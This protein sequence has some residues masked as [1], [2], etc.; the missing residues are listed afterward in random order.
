[1]GIEPRKG[2]KTE[3]RDSPR[4][5]KATLMD[6]KEGEWTSGSARSET[7]GMCGNILS[8]NRESPSLPEGIGAGRVG[9]SRDE[10]R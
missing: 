3:R 6:A 8:E 9:K 2:Y 5:A 4:K 10:R 7:P 1:M